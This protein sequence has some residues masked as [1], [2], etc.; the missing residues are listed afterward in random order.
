ME[1]IDALTML[2]GLAAGVALSAACGFRVFV[3]LLV[4]GV[5]L[6]FEALPV[7]DD[8]AWLASTPALV[9]LGTAS[10]LEV[11]AYYVPRLDNLLDAVATPASVVAGILAS[12]ALFVG[13][14]PLLQWTL[15][16]VA[17]G[18]VAGGVQ[19]G[20]VATRGV[21]TGLTGGLTNSLVSSG[22]AL[23]ALLLSVLAV[24][25]PALAAALALVALALV[26]RRGR[27]GRVDPFLQSNLAAVAGGS[28]AGG[29]HLGTIGRTLRTARA[30]E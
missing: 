14:D 17:G 7:Q 30:G 12:A 27:R 23:G 25:A 10:A 1:S 19:L 9:T 11:G 29:V 15:A 26:L 2:V 18:S 24:V 13:F 21:S 3:P 20:T 6:R 8:L 16:A 5:A 22:E 28:G 4:A